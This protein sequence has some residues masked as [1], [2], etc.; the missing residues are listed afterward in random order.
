MLAVNRERPDHTIGELVARSAELIERAERARVTLEEINE[1]MERT[2][3]IIEEQVD[4]N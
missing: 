4:R 3:E 1:E 2:Q